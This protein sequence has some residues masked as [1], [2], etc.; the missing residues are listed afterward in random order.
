MTADAATVDRLTLA[1]PDAD[2]LRDVVAR[3]FGHHR[4]LRCPAPAAMRRLDAWRRGDLQVGSLIYDSEM[5]CEVDQPRALLTFTVPDGCAGRMGRTE[6][7]PGDLLAFEP[8]WIGR[9]ELRA[10]GHFLNACFLPERALESMRALLGTDP[11]GLPAFQTQ[12][13]A[14]DP[15][16]QRLSQVLRVLQDA[17]PAPTALLQRTREQWALLEILSAWPH[18]QS[19][20]LGHGS[21]GSRP[22]RRALDFI[23]AHLDQPIT[24]QDVA[25]AA[26]IG[27]RALSEA[28]R[29]ELGQT[30]SQHLRGRRLEAARLALQRGDAPSVVDVAARWQFSN[31]GVFARYFRERFG[32]LP[33]AVRRQ[34]RH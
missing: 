1:T 24:V 28:F 17:P 30:P 23:D 22:L 27:I 5:A 25:L 4:L 16:A 31:P 8:T 3:V 34:R 15:V 10:P 19:G 32:V 9:L 11:D 20:R 26:H 6:Y 14:G 12:L 18:S 13:P 2:V 7:G 33:G 29:R 21:I